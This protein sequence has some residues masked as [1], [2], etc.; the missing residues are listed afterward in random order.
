MKSLLATSLT[1]VALWVNTSLASPE[2]IKIQALD[3]AQVF[4]NISD[5]LP[6]VMN[7]FSKQSE[8]DIIEFYQSHY[9]EVIKSSRKRD[10]L[11]SYFQFNDLT[12]RVVISQQNNARQVDVIV[13]K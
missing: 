7:Y 13:T 9:G 3:D 12:V 11:T 10:R 4:A 1:L 8:Q 2:N 5:E 6:A